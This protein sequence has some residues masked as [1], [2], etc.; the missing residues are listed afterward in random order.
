MSVILSWSLH[1]LGWEAGSQAGIRKDLERAEVIQIT[2]LTPGQ[3]AS[4]SLALLHF[5]STWRDSPGNSSQAWPGPASPLCP[6][7]FSGH[8][9]CEEREIRWIVPLKREESEL[10]VLQNGKLTFAFP[11]SWQNAG[12]G[13][14][15]QEANDLTVAKEKYKLS[16]AQ[17][18]YKWYEEV[19]R[20]TNIIS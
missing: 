12:H 13:E 17:G 10:S 8:G 4:A 3:R 20:G 14:I 2:L 15:S 9:K 11:W 16:K 18:S 7:Q 19:S 6:S 5:L 1:F